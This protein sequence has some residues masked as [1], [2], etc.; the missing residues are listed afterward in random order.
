M[1]ESSNAR[2]GIKTNRIAAC[3]PPGPPPRESSNAREGIK[4]PRRLDAM[5]YLYI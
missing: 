4:T 3:C 5:L 1:R 2:E